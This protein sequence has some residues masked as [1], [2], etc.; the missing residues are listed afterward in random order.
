MRE[1]EVEALL[2]RIEELEKII[3]EY[4]A[5]YGLT[6]PARKAMIEQRPDQARAAELGWRVEW[7]VRLMMESRG[8]GTGSDT[9]RTGIS[10]APN[11]KA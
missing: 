6:E 5:R 4:A 11:S 10:Y 8:P 1:A 7:T 2:R 3:A 9:W